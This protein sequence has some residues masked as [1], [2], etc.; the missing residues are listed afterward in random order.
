MEWMLM[1]LKRYFDFSGRSRRMEYW[2][3]IL[4]Q[5]I[6]F[7]V[8]TLLLLAFIPFA[9]ITAAEQAGVEPPPPGAGF[10]V[11][12]GIIMLL[13]L[14]FIVPT[15]AVTVRRFHDQGH[16]GWMYLL[17]FIPF[18]GGI[19]VLVFMF[20]DGNPGPN[21]WGEDPKGRDMQQ[22]FQ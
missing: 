12:L 18:F 20:L 13:W 19:I 2:M 21:Q 15:I 14:A 11:L 3:F 7:F 5:F 8:L 17:N 1:P 16:S 4:F 22:A 10:W 9:E 6:V